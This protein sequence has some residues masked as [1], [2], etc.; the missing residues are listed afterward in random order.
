MCVKIRRQAV[1]MHF[2]VCLRINAQICMRVACLRI[3]VQIYYARGGQTHYTS[4]VQHTHTHTHIVATDI[5]ARQL[6]G[7][8]P[9]TD[10]IIVLVTL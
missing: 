2:E 7:G 9:G 10:S 1:S 8:V 5:I 4:A 6:V 3:N